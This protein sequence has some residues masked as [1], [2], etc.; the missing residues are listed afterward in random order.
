MFTY[1]KNFL[2]HLLEV[3]QETRETMRNSRNK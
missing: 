1:I 3:M 2:R